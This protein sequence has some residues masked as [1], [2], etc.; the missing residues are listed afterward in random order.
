MR[1]TERTSELIPDKRRSIPE[2]AIIYIEDDVSG[3]ARVTTDEERV[4]REG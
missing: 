1:L 2:G 3:Q 4:P